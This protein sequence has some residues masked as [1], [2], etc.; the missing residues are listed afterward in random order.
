MSELIEPM[1]HLSIADLADREGVPVK[2]VYDWNTKGTGPRFM[3]IGRHVRYKLDDV[4]A[5]EE[6]RYAKAGDVA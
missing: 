1:R 6:S 4:I 2:T 5:W 3:R